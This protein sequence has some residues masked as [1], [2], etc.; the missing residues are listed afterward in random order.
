MEDDKWEAGWKRMLGRLGW[1]MICWEAGWKRMRGKRVG[2][3]LGGRWDGGGLVP[4][5]L[6]ERE[7][8]VVGMEDD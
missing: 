5:R 8:L 1:R 4:G 2:G 7:C 3:K 6:D